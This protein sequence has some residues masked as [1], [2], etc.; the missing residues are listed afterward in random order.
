M[1]PPPLWVIDQDLFRLIHV[2][3]SRPWLDPVAH[4]ANMSGLGYLQGLALLVA[5]LRQR[6]G[7]WGERLTALALAIGCA[8]IER[9][10]SAGLALVGVWL[11]VRQFQP[12]ECWWAM[13]A[14]ALSGLVRLAI[15]PL[16]S[17][18]RP[19]NFDFAQPF[20]PIFGRTSLPS[21]HATTTDRKSVV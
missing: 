19:S 20:E 8:S 21:G 12:R 11:I 14:T 1:A 9:D 10:I 4:V 15:V 16:A 17:R 5:G 7:P 2:E 3:L 6:T 13:G 18:E